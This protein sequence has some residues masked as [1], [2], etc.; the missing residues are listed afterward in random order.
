MV[1][2]QL[3]TILYL[4]SVGPTTTT[5]SDAGD[6][7]GRKTGWKKTERKTAY[8]GPKIKVRQTSIYYRDFVA[9]R[10]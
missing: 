2:L 5:D 10:Q 7:E 6:A 4:S 8:L 9:K 3:K 1:K